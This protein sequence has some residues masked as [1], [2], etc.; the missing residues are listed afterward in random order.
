MEEP[1]VAV[2]GG[3]N[4][5]ICGKAF[6]P[7]IARDS[8]PGTV[9]LSMGGVG[10]NI[11]HNLRLLGCRVVMLTAVG[12]DLYAQQVEA[13]CRRLGIDL[14]SALRV[15]EGA[16]ST[17]LV[18]EGPEGDMELALCDGA[19]AEAITPAYLASRIQVLNGAAAVVTDTNLTQEALVWLGENCR[20]PIFADPVSVTKA[21]RLA[22]V[23]GKLFCLK[24]NRL[25]AELL[26]GIPIRD[27]NSLELA[28]SKLL[29]TG[30]RRVCVSLGQEGVYCAWD[31][32]RRLE[33][34]PETRLV[35]ASGGGDAMMA[36]FVRA[37]LDR[38]SIREAAPFALACSSLAVE[39]AETVNPHL[40]L[41]AVGR[42]VKHES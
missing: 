11:A 14:G 13:D 10:R 33:P 32:Q 42:K 4:V 34:C 24:P 20:A 27:R 37:Y 30:L 3:I 41:E 31:T 1:Y 19:L 39:S 25:E 16:T 21:Q 9:R 12:G 29:S 23:L 40:S 8:N 18:I 28:A 7:L 26:S 17:Y 36:G 35:N 2:V 15:P 22:P 38:L 5:D 6:A